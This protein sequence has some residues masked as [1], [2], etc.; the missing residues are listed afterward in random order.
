VKIV[1]LCHSY[2][3]NRDTAQAGLRYY[4][5][6]PRGEGEPP[7]SLFTKEGAVS[8]AEAYQ[9]LDTHQARDYLAHRLM[10]SPAADEQPDDL[11][12]L[13]R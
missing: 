6:R 7:R 8:R 5:M 9:L 12:A 3:R 10:L 2:T 4:Q 13:T 1:I 11:W